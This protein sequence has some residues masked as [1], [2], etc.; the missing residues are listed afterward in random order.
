MVRTKESPETGLDHMGPESVVAICESLDQ[1]CGRD[2]LQLRLERDDGDSAKLNLM[3]VW[4]PIHESP[5]EAQRTYRLL[6]FEA[7]NLHGLCGLIPGDGLGFADEGSD[8]VESKGH[9]CK[10]V[11]IGQAKLLVWSRLL[12]L[13]LVWTHN[14]AQLPQSFEQPSDW[15]G[16]EARAP[17]GTATTVCRRQDIYGMFE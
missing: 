14:Q 8:F 13:Q 9:S 5:L 7:A 12:L 16:V 6:Q 4:R 1:I 10:Q 3:H 15:R 2:L 17:K 11:G